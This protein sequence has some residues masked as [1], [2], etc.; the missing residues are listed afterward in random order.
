MYD[1][2]IECGLGL[3]ELYLI[4]SKLPPLLHIVTISRRYGA[5]VFPNIPAHPPLLSLVRVQH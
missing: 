4:R 3:T 2:V 5:R 1:T